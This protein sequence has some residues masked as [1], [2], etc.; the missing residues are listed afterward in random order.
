[1]EVNYTL[2]HLHFI[3]YV[4]LFRRLLGLEDP[5][6]I[7]EIK[8]NHQEKKVDIFMVSQEDQ[9]SQVPYLVYLMVFMK[10]KNE[11]GGT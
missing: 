6:I 1:M 4:K 7:K 3:K 11:H 2:I 5:W 10:L 8:F 9:N